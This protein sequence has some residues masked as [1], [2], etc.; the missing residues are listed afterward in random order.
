M[1][2]LRI[3]IPIRFRIQNT[4]SSRGLQRD[5]VYICW[6]IAPLI[7]EAQCGG[8]G[9]LRGL[10]QWVQLC[11]YH[12]TWSPN[13]L[14]RSTSIFNLWVPVF[15]HRTIFVWIFPLSE[16]STAMFRICDIL[17]RIRIPWIRSLAYSSGSGSGFC[18]LRPS[19]LT[20]KNLLCL[21]LSVGILYIYIS[22]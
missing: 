12:V 15:R 13:K 16:I 2:F 7:Y 8:K 22:L 17:R 6:P 19:K 14:W 9:G 21:L 3:R 11:T 4:G 10:S 1:W 5:V 20:S 18:S